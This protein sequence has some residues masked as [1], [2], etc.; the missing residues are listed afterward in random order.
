[1]AV[2]KKIKR[3][4]RG[5][6]NFRTVALEAIRRSRAS[7]QERKERAEIQH[8]EP[9]TLTDTYARMSS[10]E[11]LAHFRGDREASFLTLYP[12]PMPRKSRRQIGS[13]TLT[14]GLYLVLVRSVSAA[15]IQWTRDP[16]SNYV[17]PLD[18]HR[19]IK[20]MRTDGS[21]VRVLWELN[22][23][24]HFITLARAY[25]LTND[26]RYSAEFFAQLRSWADQNPYGRGPNWTCAMEVALRA[27]NLLAAFETFRHSPELNAEFLVVLSTTTPAT[28]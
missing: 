21:D 17:W 3:A 5:E 11:L 25:S 20:L 1:M 24:G 15:D 6:V 4:V 9:L 7:L 2:L 14:R 18:Y 12:R 10:D 23:L 19:D 26:E 28:R 16:L 13:L 8:D 22:R 27:I